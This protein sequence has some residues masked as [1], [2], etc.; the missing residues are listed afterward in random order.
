[1]PC[2]LFTAIEKFLQTTLKVGVALL[3]KISHLVPIMGSGPSKA[4][5]SRRLRTSSNL[6]HPADLPWLLDV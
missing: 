1:M 3:R 4:T 2:R 6:L 5:T